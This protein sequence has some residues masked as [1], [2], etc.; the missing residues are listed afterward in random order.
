[1]SIRQAISI[2]FERKPDLRFRI[3][4]IL[5]YICSCNVPIEHRLLNS[6]VSFAGWRELV[7]RFCSG[8][9]AEWRAGLLQILIPSHSSAGI[10]LLIC[11]LLISRDPFSVSF[12][13]QRKISQD[14]ITNL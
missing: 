8:I 6:F 14:N 5:Y 7:I 2:V 12:G 13:C 1:M 9:Y 4:N 3:R 10:R 11:V